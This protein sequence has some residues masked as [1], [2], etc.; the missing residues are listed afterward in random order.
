MCNCIS[1]SRCVFSRVGYIFAEFVRKNSHE[2]VLLSVVA[3]RKRPIDAASEFDTAVSSIFKIL[4]NVSTDFLSRLAPAIDDSYY[5]FAEYICESMVYLG[6]SN[7]Q[8]VSGDGLSLY[9]QQVFVSF[10]AFRYCNFHVI[11]LSRLHHFILPG[12]DFK[13]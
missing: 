8:C 13:D 9:F 12:L 10:A 2:D 6:S 5:E 4:M 7:L 1:F 3:C 11:F